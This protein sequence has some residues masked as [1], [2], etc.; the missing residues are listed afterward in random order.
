MAPGREKAPSAAED[1]QSTG[2][3]RQRAVSPAAI[4]RLFTFFRLSGIM[5]AIQTV[6]EA[7]K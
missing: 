6:M 7:D 1:R 4:I 3:A 2:H 5:T